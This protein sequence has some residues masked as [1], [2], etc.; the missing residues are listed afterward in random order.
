MR[1]P[2][3]GFDLAP[4]DERYPGIER[5]IE[6]IAHR[7]CNGQLDE[8]TMQT[9]IV[10]AGLDDLRSGNWGSPQLPQAIRIFP[11][12]RLIIGNQ[13]QQS[14]PQL[15][16]AAFHWHAVIDEVSVAK[17]LEQTGVDELF[18]VLGDARLALRHEPGQLGYTA[19]AMG[20]Q[21]HDPQTDRVGQGLELRDELLA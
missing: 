18:D 9:A 15:P 16:I 21:R 12:H 7:R 1:V 2:F 20:A 13:S 8:R 10:F 11:V 17:A 6:Q 4:V 14:A 5:A 19:L 3:M